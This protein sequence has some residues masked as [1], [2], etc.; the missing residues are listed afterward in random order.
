MIPSLKNGVLGSNLKLLFS[1]I[2]VN[3]TESEKDNDSREWQTI[4]IVE[5]AI[6]LS[7][8]ISMK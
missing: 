2:S 6:K 7:Q 3:E 5:E 4:D 8:R 1:I